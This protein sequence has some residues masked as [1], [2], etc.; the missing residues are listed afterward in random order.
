MEGC[1]GSRISENFGEMWCFQAVAVP[2]GLKK[3]SRFK[4]CSLQNGLDTLQSQGSR[5][6]KYLSTCVSSASTGTNRQALSSLSCGKPQAMPAVRQLSLQLSP[7]ARCSPGKQG[8]CETEPATLRCHPAVEMLAKC[9]V[10][11]FSCGCFV[12]PHVQHS[13]WT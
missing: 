8:L 7:P 1:F 5:T 13:L 2:P 11:L 10:C 3:R 12:L 4:M 6:S 9:C